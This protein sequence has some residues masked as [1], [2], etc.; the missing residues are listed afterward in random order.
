MTPPNPKSAIFSRSKKIPLHLNLNVIKSV[1]DKNPIPTAIINTNFEYEY[2]NESYQRI[3]L[4]NKN[5]FVGKHLKDIFGVD[6]FYKHL[7]H[8]INKIIDGET[9]S[10]KLPSHENLQN[11][12]GTLKREFKPLYDQK[13]N[14]IGILLTSPNNIVRDELKE[15]II[16]NIDRWNAIINTLDDIIFILDK[17]LNL[18][19]V[20]N[21]ATRVFGIIN[22]KKHSI[23]FL[24]FFPNL[25][26]V[27]NISDKEIHTT[28]KNRQYS[29]KA[30]HT[31]ESPYISDYT[32]IIFRDITELLMS[33]YE[34]K[35]NQ[36]LLKIKNNEYLR[37]NSDLQIKNIRIEN[38][39]KILE[40]SKKNYQQLF[41]QMNS[42]LKILM[43]IHTPEGKIIDFIITEVNPAFEELSG[44]KSDYLIGKRIS[45]L[46]NFSPASI[47]LYAKYA[48]SGESAKLEEFSE[49]F[50]KYLSLYIYTP[51]KG[52]LAV[53]IKDINSRKI[54]EKELIEHKE[55]FRMALSTAELTVW[56][57]DIKNRTI[58]KIT[59]SK[60]NHIKEKQEIVTPLEFLHLVHPDDLTNVLISLRK[61]LYEVRSIKTEFRI[62]DNTGKTQWILI[63]TSGFKNHDNKPTRLIFTSHIISG[64]KRIT[65][66]LKESKNQYK[67]II[68]NSLDTII[69]VSGLFKIDYINPVG[70]RLFGYQNRELISKD[71]SNIVTFADRNIAQ[72]L[73]REIQQGKRHK[74]EITCVKNDGTT[75]T[76]EIIANQVYFE[77]IKK[78]MISLKDITE[79]KNAQQELIKA[80]EKAEES[81]RLKSAFLANMSH[82][83]RTPMNGIIG[84]SRLLGKDNIDSNTRKSYIDV[85][86]KTTN[87]LLNIINDIISISKIEAGQMTLNLKRIELNKLFTETERLHSNEIEKKGLSLVTV[88]GKNKLN[89]IVDETKLKQILTNLL[90]NATKFTQ[91]GNIEMGYNL[92]N[93]RVNFYVKDTGIGIDKKNQSIIFE[94]FRQAELTTSRRFGGTGLGLSIS[95]A[96]INLMGGEMELISEPNNGS[97]F[98]FSLPYTPAESSF[99]PES[100]ENND[101]KDQEWA[102][103]KILIAEDEEINFLYLFELLRPTGI[104]IIRAENGEEAIDLY[105]SNKDVRVILMDVKMP[106]L[107]GYEATKHIRKTDIEIP[108][109]ALTAY[110]LEEDKQRAIEAGCTLHLSKPILPEI[111]YDALK[112]YIY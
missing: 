88:L 70:K 95:K 109:I 110:A 108:I 75:F 99:N 48:L 43:P 62:I 32:V 103:K 53:I 2:A 72:E 10:V 58:L 4:A 73:V 38:V 52:R 83:I 101:P 90:S 37:L 54:A 82:E 14:I 81:D 50:N 64:R 31:F 86:Q 85:V 63:R 76:A 87:Q 77:G 9:I 23:P 22:D 51:T 1:L 79:Q 80:K 98:L 25:K 66:A 42:A 12:F 13:D 59:R 74:K 84:F 8:Q 92:N 102:G 78:I 18:E 47:K 29:V 100:E 5:N 55:R 96:F 71:I 69:I 61:A 27:L 30:I 24:E 7:E 15:N 67:M 21:S 20:N 34:L 26:E 45:E 44:K 57:W 93:E 16:K 41:N 3:F 33:S 68:N 104:E 36:E 60:K 65:E 46:P 56:D 91:K 28:I 39:N 112:K 49:Q 6:F 11:S 89:L 111:L 17:D 19:F 97:T 35:Q 107:D 105:N 94:R 106:V 40:K